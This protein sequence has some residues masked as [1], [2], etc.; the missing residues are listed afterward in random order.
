M[1]SAQRLRR[2][3]HLVLAH[4]PTH[5][6]VQLPP[7][8]HSNLLADRRLAAH[9][10]SIVPC[11]TLQ[12]DRR[13]ENG[14]TLEWSPEGRHLLVATTAPRLRV[15]NG[16]QVFKY[17]GT[18]VAR[19]KRD[20][21]LE[22]QVRGG[23]VFF[24]FLR[25][26]GGGYIVATPSAQAAPLLCMPLMNSPRHSA[27]YALLC[28][29]WVPVPDTF[30]DRPQS[31]RGAGAASSSGNGSSNGAAALPQPAAR[32]AGYVPPHLR[33]RPEAAAV[34]AAAFSLARDPS[35]KGGKIG[36]GG[37]SRPGSGSGPA[38]N[39]PPG[40][41]PPASKVASKNA[42]RRAAAAKKKAEEGV[43]GLQL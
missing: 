7:A 11:H 8:T 14:V 23:G 16:I 25:E 24:F 19:E 30:E 28:L 15:D 35:D 40:A 6:H 32:Q 42:K 5:L 4:P 1:W 33:G 29:Q 17:D 9:P 37:S 13:A 43:A 10:S 27:A 38:A 18:L 12:R 20:V 39:L 34:A 21:L 41:A 2:L 22:A 3:S 31:P 26:G 36:G